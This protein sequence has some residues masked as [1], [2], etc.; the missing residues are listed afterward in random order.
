MR[1]AGLTAGLVLAAV[2]GIAAAPARAEDQ[3]SNS[4]VGGLKLVWGSV[5]VPQFSPGTSAGAGF[6]AGLQSPPAAYSLTLATPGDGPQQFSFSPRVPQLMPD[7][8]AAAGN[9]R[10]Y[11][12]VSIDVGEPSTGLFGTVGLGGSVPTNRQASFEDTAGPRALNAPLLLH[13]GFEL[14]YRVDTQNTFT[15]SIDRALPAEGPD[16]NDSMGGVRLRYGL[17][18]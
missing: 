5:P 3:A 10:T 7:S 11:L 2:L 18:F 1:R 12:G 14:G 17:K 6:G 8:T 4:Y 9:R 16:R 15:L 13:G